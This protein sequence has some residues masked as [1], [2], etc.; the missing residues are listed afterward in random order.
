MSIIKIQEK[1]FLLVNVL[2]LTHVIMIEKIK[3]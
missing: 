3:T 1:I 2:S